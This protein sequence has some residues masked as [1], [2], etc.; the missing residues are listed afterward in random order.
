MQRFRSILA[1]LMA[2]CLVGLPSSRAPAEAATI[3]SIAETF[4]TSAPFAILVDADTGT[5]LFEKNIDTP[6]APASTAKI[7]TA[8]V[9]FHAIREG[10]LKL[11]DTFVISENA[12][13][14]GG[15]SSG[16][17]S[18]FAAL[19]SFVRIEDLIRGLVIQSGNDAAIA[20]AEG[21][22]GSEESSPT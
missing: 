22:A 5:V 1:A 6:M 12:W 17:S 9:V 7:L 8:E 14:K 21:L 19:N 18:M 11:D 16:G 2:F 3:G 20:L 15:A 4:Q 10:R 13:R